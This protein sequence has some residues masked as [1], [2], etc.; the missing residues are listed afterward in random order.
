MEWFPHVNRTREWYELV[1]PDGTLALICP[2][3]DDEDKTYLVTHKPINSLVADVLSEYRETYDDFSMS[4][5]I[6]QLLNYKTIMMDADGMPDYA[7]YSLEKMLRY[8]E[9]VHQL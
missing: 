4:D 2:A 7:Y 6:K 5:G 8:A 1:V 9:S 3:I